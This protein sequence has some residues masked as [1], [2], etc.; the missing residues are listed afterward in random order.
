MESSRISCE[1][2]MKQCSTREAQC[3]LGAHVNVNCAEL[4][5]RT[6]HNN[7]SF[8]ALYCAPSENEDR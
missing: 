5:I 3:T 1:N 2:K 7:T 4:H 8:H 6:S